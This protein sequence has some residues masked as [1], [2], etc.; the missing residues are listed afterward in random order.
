VLAPGEM[1]LHSPLVVHGSNPNRSAGRR[2]GFAIRYIP[3]D[4]HQ[5]GGRRNSATLVRG[6]DHGHLERER[7]PEGLFHPDAVSRHKDAL[8]QG[9]NVIFD[10]NPPA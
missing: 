7:A 9:F 8:R 1:S 6:R 3:G 4:N 5:T 10:G 2:T